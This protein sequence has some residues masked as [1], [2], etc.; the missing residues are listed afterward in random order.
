MT[1]FP[2][3]PFGPVSGEDMATW[4]DLLSDDNQ[5]HLSRAAAE[6]AGF[7]PNRVNPGPANLAFL[8]SAAMAADPE[9]G[10]TRIDAR[11]EGNVVEGDHV[12]ARNEGKALALYRDGDDR[13]VVTASIQFGAIE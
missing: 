10:V 3:T 11:F 8:L 4:C 6:A 9:A 7:G 5:I 13:P 12:I 1:E 2:D